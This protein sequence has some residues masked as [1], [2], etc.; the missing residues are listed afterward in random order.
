MDAS[1]DAKQFGEGMSRDPFG[2]EQRD[3]EFCGLFYDFAFDE[4]VRQSSLDGKTRFLAI[5][6]ALMGCQGTEAFSGSIRRSWL[7]TG[8]SSSTSKSADAASL[9]RKIWTKAE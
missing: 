2:L 7:A 9:W 5:L 3:P 4:V 6:A 8:R 1:V